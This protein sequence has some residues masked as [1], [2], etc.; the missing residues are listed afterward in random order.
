MSHFR[1]CFVL[2]NKIL[3]LNNT[4]YDLKTLV[5]YKV[6]SIFQDFRNSSTEAETWDALPFIESISINRT[7]LKFVSYSWAKFKIKSKSVLIFWFSYEIDS[8]ILI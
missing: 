7:I 2:L 8:K 6:W 3:F 5:K 1:K 4:I